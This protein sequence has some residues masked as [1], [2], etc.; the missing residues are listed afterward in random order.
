MKNIVIVG[1][2]DEFV[3]DFAEAVALTI[4]FQHV[5]F[6]FEFEKEL[7]QSKD[8]PLTE[9]DKLMKDKETKILNHL[10]NKDNVVLSVSNNSFLANLKNDL[11]NKSF[12]ILIERKEN[13]KLSKNIQK[14][15]KKY[16]KISLKQEK[17]NLNNL[18]SNILKHFNK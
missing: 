11:F 14:L 9:V 5:N 4:G 10:L 16:C 2:D 13:E 3:V 12:T 7:V 8:Y 1:L 6:D 18:K 15:I 17:I